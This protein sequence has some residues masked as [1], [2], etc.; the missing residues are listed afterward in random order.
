MGQLG[1]QS[2][3]AARSS[4]G[5]VGS[6]RTGLKAPVVSLRAQAPSSLLALLQ[7]RRGLSSLSGEI[8]PGSL[9]VRYHN[10]DNNLTQRSFSN[11]GL[12][13]HPF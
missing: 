1:G 3:G 10:S 7:G 13:V 6:G 2:R 5:A 11:T 8:C 9:W 4:A 12:E